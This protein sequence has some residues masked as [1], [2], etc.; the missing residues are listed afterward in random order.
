M[1]I[2]ITIDGVLNP[3]L[4][5]Y[6]VI[7][8]STPIDPSDATGGVGQFTFGM[9]ANDESRYLLDKTVELSDGSQGSTVGTIGATSN[10][11]TALTVTVDSRLALLSAQRQAQPF[12]GTL[13]DAFIYYLGLVGITSGL[14]VDTSISATAVVFPGW[15]GNAWDFMKKMATA[16]G[17]EV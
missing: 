12:V 15:S 5:A 17:V 6:S 1:G 7:E 10:L 16:I 9:T 4:T 13:S 2:D 3:N 11:N 14:V 8:D